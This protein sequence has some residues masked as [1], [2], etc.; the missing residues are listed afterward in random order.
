MKFDTENCFL[1][2]GG[3]MQKGIEIAIKDYI[4]SFEALIN[5][6]SIADRALF[7]D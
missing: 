4:S 5:Y 1:V 3:L 2:R 6:Y 7:V